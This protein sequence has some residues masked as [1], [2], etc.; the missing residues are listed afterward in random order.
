M[1][2]PCPATCRSTSHREEAVTRVEFRWDGLKVKAETNAGLYAGLL[3]AGEY[4]RGES[5]KQAPI[6]EGLL[7]ASAELTPISQRKVAV[8]YTMPYAVRQHEEL[9]YRH[10]KGGKAKYLED[11][12]N[13]GKPTMMALIAKEAGRHMQ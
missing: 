1:V 9:A 5:S 10:P 3:K 2:C 7:R 8:H 13:A 4:L 6:R 12:F 11:P